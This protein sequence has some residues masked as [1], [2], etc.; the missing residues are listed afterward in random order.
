LEKTLNKVNSCLREV[1]VKA[2]EEEVKPIYEQTLE[3]YT[4]NLNIPGFRKG[5]APLHMVLKLYG[6]DIDSDFKEEV[7]NEFLKKILEEEKLNP[8]SRAK[9]LEEEYKKGEFFSF[10]AQF[11]IMPEFELAQ[12]KDL[13][14]EKI[15]Y[16]VKDQDVEFEINKILESQ[17]E[18]IDEPKAL[19]E[20][21]VVT[22]DVQ[23]TDAAGVP[24]L[25]HKSENVPI[26]L[27][28]PTVAEDIRK[29]LMNTVVGDEVKVFIEPP[30]D[31]EDK[32]FNA[33]LTIKKIQKISYPEIDEKLIKKITR[34][35]LSTLDELKNEIRTNLE[36]QYVSLGENIL[37][38]NIDSEL[39]RKNEFDVPEVMIENYLHEMIDEMKQQYPN[40]TL[41]SNF[42][43]QGYKEKNRAYAIMKIKTYFIYLKIM[44]LEKIKVDDVD[45]AL[46]AETESARTGIDKD[47]LVNYYKS[48]DEVKEKIL[49]KKLNTF[50]IE[51]NKIT[52]KDY[53]P[54]KEENKI[55][56]E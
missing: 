11:E 31:T 14:V 25:G 16:K 55:I 15:N 7:I 43:L 28:E 35:K 8:V 5:K 26:P 53:E 10:K 23:E 22:A 3:R 48:S 54:G 24:L 32:P 2:T 46:H 47:R 18:L 4:K 13:E 29:K 17:R 50:M 42:D 27:N 33:N 30:K 51:N 56:A 20:K 37:K 12:Y 21:Y 40:K 1:V 34:D 9:I 39:I 36:K 38:S 19:D 41:P 45:L 6:K 44:E 49:Q 52:E